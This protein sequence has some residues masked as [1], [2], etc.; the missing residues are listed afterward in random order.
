MPDARM[1]TAETLKCIEG[2]SVLSRRPRRR[3]PAIG[4]PVVTLVATRI[5]AAVV[6]AIRAVRFILICV[7]VFL[8]DHV[9]FARSV[10]D[11]FDRNL[12]AEKINARL[13]LLA[14]KLE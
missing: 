14:G 9:Y 1:R 8:T 3:R 12:R 6:G 2:R 5:V 11:F 13:T 7:H 10:E 4:V